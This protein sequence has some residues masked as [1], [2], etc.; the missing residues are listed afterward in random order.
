ME[1]ASLEESIRAGDVWTPK[2]ETTLINLEVLVVDYEPIGYREGYALHIP[3]PNSPQIVRA[4]GFS[5][6][7]V[8]AITL[9]GEI[10]ISCYPSMSSE[11]L[12]KDEPI[13]ADFLLRYCDYY[14]RDVD[15]E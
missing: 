5:K 9:G 10:R 12:A 14:K 2:Y 4:L 13:F 7:E 1:L 11:S 3:L 8:D 6:S 15:A